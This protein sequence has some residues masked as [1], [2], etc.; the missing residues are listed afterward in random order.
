MTTAAGGVSRGVWAGMNLGDHVGDIPR[1]V[2]ANRDH[3]AQVLG[4]RPVFMRQVHGVQ[5]AELAPDSPDG[6]QADGA[7]SR[8]SGLA[9]VVMVADC[10]PIL[11]TH[12]RVP[13][14]AALHAGWRG[15]AGGGEGGGIVEAGWHRLQAATGLAAD[16]LAPGLMAWLGPCIGPQ[17]FEV[18]PE[19]RQAFVQVQPEA[20]ACFTGIASRPGKFLA[21][22]PALARLR[23]AR[24]GITRV[25]GNDGSADWCTVGRSRFFSHRRVSGRPGARPGETGGRMAACIWLG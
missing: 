16:E 13:V 17:A 10:L 21:D 7:L 14:V 22:L 19:V 24:L 12:A 5:V 15:L 20:G 25:F 2:A 9:C 23:L 6:L 1:D 8:R 18:G 11:L 4:A 3:L